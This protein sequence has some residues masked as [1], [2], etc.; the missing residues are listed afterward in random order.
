GETARPTRNYANFRNWTLG[1]ATTATLRVAVGVLALAALSASAVAEAASV[2]PRDRLLDAVE[3]HAALPAALGAEIERRCPEA[4]TRCAAQLIVGSLLAARLV[5]VSH[6]DTDTIR[7]AHTVPSVSAVERHSDGAL[8]L[9]LDRFGRTADREVA[10]AIAAAGPAEA[11]RV[12]LDLRGNAGGDFDRMRRVASL[13]TGPREGA[14]RLLGRAGATDVALPAPLRAIGEF[15]LDVLIGPGTASSAEVL[16][17]LLRRHAGA[18]LVGAPTLGKDWLT[19]L[20]PVDHDWRLAIPAERI[21]VPGETLAQGLAPD[22]EATSD[23]RQAD[24]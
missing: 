3:R 4:G 9:V 16:A 8:V 1:A 20:V 12:V 15:E 17:A 6:P 14:I 24:E 13:F 22:I 7:R 2:A 21:E 23:E 11:V 10:D 5:P 18:R 19:R